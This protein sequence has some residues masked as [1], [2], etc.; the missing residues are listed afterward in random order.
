ML[1]KKISET[2]IRQNHH[3][4]LL[5]AL[6]LLLA[7]RVLPALKAPLSTYGYDFGFYYYAASHAAWHW[8]DFLQSVWGGYNSIIFLL[9]AIIHLPPAVTL[10]GSYFLSAIF[11]GVT[12]Y[13]L[14]SGGAGFGSTE[15]KLS[16]IT[17]VL[18][19]ILLGCSLFQAE[20]YSMF[21][22]KNVVALPFL[23]LS[24]KYLMDKNYKAFATCAAA[25]LLLHRTT[26]IILILTF[27][28]YLI[29]ELIKNK[30]YKIL[31]ALF[32]GALILIVTAFSFFNFKS[33]ILNLI[34][35]NNYY[36]RTGLFL[37]NQN[38]L[39][40]WWPSLILAIAG[41]ALYLKRK[42][43]P[44]LPIFAGLC[45]AWV[46]FKFPFYRRMLVYLDLTVI[47]FA[48]YFLDK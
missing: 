41:L 6:T 23:V 24:F 33:I 13:L 32:S 27:S 10:S 15:K 21:L 36:V 3:V 12:I 14:M 7:I 18:A 45:L 30:A 46:V 8:R 31:L 16:S 48:A 38:L 20:L 25:V 22:W 11:L 39:L 29:Y 28:L 47:C 37:E 5:L 2:K 9:G 1:D 26:A 17:G 43:H 34:Y 4:F 44:L 40:L 19:V 35:N 42:Q